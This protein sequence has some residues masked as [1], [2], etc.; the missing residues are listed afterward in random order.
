MEHDS[1]PNIVSFVLR[2]IRESGDQ[3]EDARQYRGFIHHIQTN[4][5]FVFTQWKDAVN[6]I[7]DYVPI[8]NMPI[9]DDR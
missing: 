2:F 8:E 9:D 4:E 6:F 3:P 1:Q 5:E 7:Q